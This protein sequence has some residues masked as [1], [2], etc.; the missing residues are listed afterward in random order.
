MDNVLLIILISMLGPVIGS[1]VG[2]L[3]YPSRKF[4]MAMLSFAAGVMLSVSFLYLIPESIKFSSIW[5]C[6]FGV[7]AGCLA[8]FAV[9]KIIPHMHRRHVKPENTPKMKKAAIYLLIGIFMH[10]FPEG[11]AMAVGV[12]PGIKMSLAVAIA[13]TIHNIPEG[14]CTSSPYYYYT[15]K[16][17]RSFLISVSTALPEIIGFLFAY[18]LYSFLPVNTIGF[19]LAATAGIMVYISADE[20]IPLSCS[21]DTSHYAIFSLIAGVILVLILGLL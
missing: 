9:D 19:L 20:L 15:K 14:V 6:C 18:Y 13:I 10:N 8:I 4:M 11:M 2:V 5:I 16:R 3:K 1:A 21:D 17:L 12:V 7:V